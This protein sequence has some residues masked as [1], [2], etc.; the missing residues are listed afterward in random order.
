MDCDRHWPVVSSVGSR[1]ADVRRVGPGGGK[2][3]KCPKCEGE[4]TVEAEFATHDPALVDV[5]L[6]C[7]NTH[8]GYSASV[9]VLTGQFIEDN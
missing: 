7:E 9:F 3:M 2:M 1:R 4:L 8:C 6:L 5:R